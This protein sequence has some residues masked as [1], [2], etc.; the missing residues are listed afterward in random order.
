MLKTT[1]LPTPLYL[2]LNLKVMQ[3]ECEEIWRQITKIMGQPYMV[4]KSWS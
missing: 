2:T 4:K 3:L 1:F